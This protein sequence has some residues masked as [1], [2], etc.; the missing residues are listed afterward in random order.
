MFAVHGCVGTDRLLGVGD[1]VEDHGL[2]QGGVVAQVQLRH[3]RPVGGAVELDLRIAERLA[4]PLQVERGD[5]RGVIAHA[6]AV[7]GEA[8]ERRAPEGG[9]LV[10]CLLP[11]FRVV[12]EQRLG[13]SGAALIEQDDVV[14]AIDA[15][16]R[17]GVA[18]VKIARRLAGAARPARTAARRAS[19]D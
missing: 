2:H 3:A 15:R 8:V 10:A 6:L 11:V 17:A 7:V 9:Q 13:L 5:T 4:N 19:G 18:H 14:I 1:A 16:E 12:A